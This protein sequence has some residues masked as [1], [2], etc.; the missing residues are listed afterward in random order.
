MTS[1][2]TSY[3]WTLP[4]TESAYHFRLQ[5]G[6]QPNNCDACVASSPTFRIEHSEYNQWP[7]QT[8]STSTTSSL[9]YIPTAT[10]AVAAAAADTTASAAGSSSGGLSH[11][12]KV[13]IGVGL[14]LGIGVPIIILSIIFLCLF[15]RRRQRRRHQIQRLDQV[16]K[17]QQAM[18]RAVPP[19]APSPPTRDGTRDGPPGTRESAGAKSWKTTTS[20][21][22]TESYHG[23]FEFEEELGR[24]KP[25]W[26]RLFGRNGIPYF[27]MPV[28]S[29]SG[30]L[31][32]RS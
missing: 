25:G 24:V 7:V 9:P 5:K 17:R 30:R 14:G 19:L 23:P 32:F 6:D 26:E 2:E 16:H 13:G 3:T 4:T 10:P 15:L 18:Q 1:N 29:K 12:A 8:P 22:T 20:S 31:V 27:G 21:K 28:R 11:S